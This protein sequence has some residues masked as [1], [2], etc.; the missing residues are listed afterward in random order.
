MI[1]PQT[2]WRC[3]STSEP[4]QLKYCRTPG[5]LYWYA[6]SRNKLVHR[7]VSTVSFGTW[8]TRTFAVQGNCTDAIERIPE[9]LER[10]AVNSK[11]CIIDFQNVARGFEV[12]SS[13]SL[14]LSDL[15]ITNT[16][17]S[18]VSSPAETSSEGRK[19]LESAKFPS[20]GAQASNA[21][22]QGPDG[23]IVVASDTSSDLNMQ[24]EGPNNSTND[25]DGSDTA[26]S[27]AA[28]GFTVGSGAELPMLDSPSGSGG[29]VYIAA[30][31]EIQGGKLY[32]QRVIFFN[33]RAVNGGAVGLN[34]FAL[35]QI[36]DCVFDS[37]S[38]S[39]HG[40]MQQAVSSQDSR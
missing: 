10:E 4:L 2:S 6:A 37:N 40:G 7:S 36:V 9:Q 28:A 29:A 33:N 16:G 31:S 38:A 17:P 14:W 13:S 21:A 19:L 23:S 27:S 20:P 39:G 26:R 11:H 30:G 12:P 3:S 35:A 15:I 5:Q 32:A 18:A 34:K 1:P 8:A 24:A 25:G 22:A